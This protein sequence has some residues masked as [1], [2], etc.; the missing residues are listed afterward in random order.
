MNESLPAPRR[1]LF[2]IRNITG[3][4]LLIAL[5][6]V[7]LVSGISKIDS[8]QTFEWSFIDLGVRNFTVAAILARLLI[9]LELLI[10]GFLLSHLFLRSFTYPLT[11]GL[12][13]VFTV[14]LILL[15]MQQGNEGNCG[16]FGEWIYMSPLSSIWKNLGMMAVT[17]LLYFLYPGK[18]TQGRPLMALAVGLAALAVPFIANPM[19]I[20]SSPK[21]V[22][23]PLDMNV[24][25]EA[26][27][28]P[29]AVELR[30]G[31]HVVAFM[32]LTCPHCR[33][34]AYLLQLIHRQHP[35]ISIFLVLTG[36]E[37][38]EEDFFKETQARPVP[39]MF[40]RETEAFARMAGPAIPAIYWVN[41]SV[42]E[43][44]ANY[45]Q[46]DP[47]KIRDWLQGR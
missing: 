25:Y 26:G 9:G 24:L 30:E 42:I 29:P 13:A 46:L 38:F 16:C 18:G 17:L 11:I 43:R 45:F 1:R 47:A 34:A 40:F 39:H 32:S 35:D 7:F 31:K 27:T 15:M 8:L 2:S 21:V 41:N 20:G 22:N 19:N 5:A 28:P 33:K 10:A 23:E 6:A 36:P 12:L 44:K 37:E 14:Y 3:L 4:L